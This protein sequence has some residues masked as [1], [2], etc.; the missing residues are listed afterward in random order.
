VARS[1]RTAAAAYCQAVLRH[2]QRIA[3]DGAPAEPVAAE[4][5]DLAAKQLARLAARQAAKEEQRRKTALLPAPWRGSG[6]TPVPHL[7]FQLSLGLDRDGVAPALIVADQ[8]GPDLEVGRRARAV[9]P[10]EAV[11]EFERGT[12][13]RAKS[14]FLNPGGHH[15]PQ[16]VRREAL[17]RHACD[18]RR[19]GGRI[20][21]QQQH[22]QAARGSAP[23]SGL[24][25]TR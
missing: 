17:A 25:V 18:L 13:K 3:L 20:D 19:D 23:A 22:G 2:D 9:A 8:H 4:T 24:S 21:N 10:G 5:K 6:A 1:Q 15:P 11:Q 14:L 16:Q 12:V 7:S